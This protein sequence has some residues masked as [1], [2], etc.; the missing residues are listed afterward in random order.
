MIHCCCHFRT[1]YILTYLIVVTLLTLRQYLN[2]HPVLDGVRVAHV[3]RVL[4]CV[5]FVFALCFV[6][7]NVAGVSGL[8]IL[9][10]SFIFPYIYLYGPIMPI[11]FIF[12]TLQCLVLRLD[13]SYMIAEIR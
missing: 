9:D 12:F 6:V 13:I 11:L 5:L 3:L 1:I 7:T 8:S 10:C 4:C 2:S